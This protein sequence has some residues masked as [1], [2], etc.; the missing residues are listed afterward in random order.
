MY[1]HAQ[2]THACVLTDANDEMQTP[3]VPTSGALVSIIS[4]DAQPAA[5]TNDPQADAHTEDD[6]AVAMEGKIMNQGQEGE[7]NRM[8]GG[9][10]GQ[11]TTQTSTTLPITGVM[12]SGGPVT[13]TRTS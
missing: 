4:S 8:A 2:H 12:S 13:E 6:T 11:H 5:T 7:Q 1:P 3:S 10:A 9:G